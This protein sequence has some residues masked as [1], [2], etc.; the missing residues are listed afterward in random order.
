MTEVH[1]GGT[2]THNGKKFKVLNVVRN[3][4]SQNQMVLF[5]D[6]KNGNLWVRTM[7]EFLKYYKLTCTL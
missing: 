5:E 6:I 3:A 4:T 7:S 2:Y 1:K